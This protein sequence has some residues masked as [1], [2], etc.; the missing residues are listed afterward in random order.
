MFFLKDIKPLGAKLMEKLSVTIITRNEEK[1]IARC[2]ESVKWADEIVVL[3]TN[4]TDRTVEICRQFTDQ[5][6]CVD[7]NG[8]GKQKNLCADRTSHNWVLNIDS[9]EEI[10]AEGAEEIR[11]VLRD[12]SKYFVYQFPRKNFF[13][14]RW[15]RYG[16]WYPDRISRLYDKTKVSFTESQVHEKL[17]PDENV[18]FMRNSIFH[19][20]FSGME[21]YIE[22][23]NL[24]STLYAREKVSQGFRASWTH[25]ILRPPAAFLKNYIIRLGFRD[26][27]LG[28]FLAL[29]FAFYT[30]L[31]YAK[32]K[33]I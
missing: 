1:N 7:W 28:L 4:S 29:S 12:G 26:G 16:G 22:R 9:D 27:F 20:S 18:G 11:A 10:S 31:K 5:V 3:D 33:S 17:V 13:G 21:D 8:Y 23:Q 15:V 30:F 25:L 14:Q 6:F 19:H 2:L 24:Y 32:T